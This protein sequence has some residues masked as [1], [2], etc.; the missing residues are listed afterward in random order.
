MMKALIDAWGIGKVCRVCKTLKPKASFHPHKYCPQGI[1]STCRDC[2]GVR[3]K[4]WYKDNRD[5]RQ[6]A[7]N[8][9]NKEKKLKAIEYLG[10][11]CHDCE[12]QYEPC[13]YDFH[14][15]DGTKEKNPSAALAGSFEKAKEELDKCV[16]LCA[17]CH[18]LRH[19]GK[20]V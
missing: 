15:V 10:G 3:I 6:E 9:R 12:Q 11:R 16:L 1:V 19:F 8:K 18:R 20:E 7:S 14:H 4:Q 13:V 5:R 2:T 17:N